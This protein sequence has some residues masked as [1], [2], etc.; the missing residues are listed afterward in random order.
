MESGTTW[1]LPHAVRVTLT[2][3][4]SIRNLYTAIREPHSYPGATQQSGSHTAIRLLY[5]IR[6]SSHYLCSQYPDSLN[7]YLSAVRTSP[8]PFEFCMQQSEFSMASIRVPYYLCSQNPDSPNCYSCSQN[9]AVRTY[10]TLTW[11]IRIPL[12]ASLCNQD[13]S[14]SFLWNPE[15]PDHSLM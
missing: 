7:C 6:A 14:D 2:P 3:Y 1:L 4:T 8:I 12:T 10:L 11:A 9:Y 5:T 15:P 13:H